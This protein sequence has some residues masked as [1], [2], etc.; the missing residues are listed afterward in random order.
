MVIDI[1]RLP[2]EGLQISRDF[3]FP[4]ND[5]V[6]ESAVFLEPLHADL[7]V[8]KTGEEISVKGRISAL[9]SFICSRCLT[10]FEFAID[11]S[12]DL[13]YLP[14]EFDEI[15]EELT[16]EDMGQLF[17]YKQ[18]LDL[19]EVILEQLNLTFPMKPLCSPDCQGICPVCGRIIREGEC[20]CAVE[21]TDPRLDKLKSFIK[22]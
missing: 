19:G 14:E 1:E 7:A 6:E 12:F 21:T 18:K 15:K 2:E 13:I 17:Y 9:L 8:K 20:R 10:P 4:S 16:E 5:L 3:E 11:S 22:R